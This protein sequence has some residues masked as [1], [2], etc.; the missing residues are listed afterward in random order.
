MTPGYVYIF[1]SDM[2]ISQGL[3]KIGKSKDPKSRLSNMST[4]CLGGKFL[5][6]S[7]CSNMDNVELFM[8]KDLTSKGQNFD[9]EW[10]KFDSYDS[11]LSYFN[12]RVF[13]Y[14]DDESDKPEPFDI[15]QSDLHDKQITLPSMTK[16]RKLI[17][18]KDKI[19]SKIDKNKVKWGEDEVKLKDKI[20]QAQKHLKDK[21]KVF[22]DS[23]R[24]LDVQFKELTKNINEHKVMNA[25]KAAMNALHNGE[26]DSKG[27]KSIMDIIL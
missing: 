5:Y 9:K 2:Y 3:F 17:S 27:I 8:H 7:P 1:S 13:R 4:S 25:G 6:V 23:N 14:D 22:I 21:K 19:Q 12:D 16:M 18:D 26:I 20:D 11:C 15:S 10:F 24:K